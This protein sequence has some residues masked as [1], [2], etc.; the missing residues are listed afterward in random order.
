[1]IAKDFC[2]S[3]RLLAVVTMSGLCACTTTPPTAIVRGGYSLALPQAFT[4]ITRSSLERFNMSRPV[5]VPGHVVIEPI[6]M[7]EGASGYRNSGGCGVARVHVP[8]NSPVYLLPLPDLV[9]GAGS[10]LVQQWKQQGR[11]EPFNPWMPAQTIASQR[12]GP[13]AIAGLLGWQE[14]WF[15]EWAQQPG[16]FQ[17][18][19]LMMVWLADL[20]DPRGA[21]TPR[22][23][24]QITCG[25][26]DLPPYLDTALEEVV[27]VVKQLH[28]LPAAATESRP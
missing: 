10:S 25:T 17:P 12:S 7:F 28:A 21:A 14:T 4:D 26:V 5:S 3:I 23:V 16:P 18:G 9:R 13:L 2:S 22:Q 27:G 11:D 19:S 20:S 8:A 15:I 24:L 1:M 6:L